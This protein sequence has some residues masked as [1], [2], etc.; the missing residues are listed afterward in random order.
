MAENLISFL[1]I[2]SLLNF[3]IVFN[4]FTKIYN[5]RSINTLVHTLLLTINLCSCSR[6]SQVSVQTETKK[7]DTLQEIPT[8]IQ[9]MND[10]KVNYY[11]AVEAFNAYWS[12]H[13]KPT[14]D[15]GEARDIYGKEKSEA[16]KKAEAS[17]SVQYVYEYKQFLNWMERN[18]NLVKTD[19]TLMT[20]AEILEQ[21]E[22]ERKNRQ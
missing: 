8:W 6:I 21:S 13:E 17:R 10:P 12:K 18:K 7:H 15:S 14:E 16:E 2:L 20:P 5:M 11:Q 3:S 19:G 9:M 1:P 4:T 22:K